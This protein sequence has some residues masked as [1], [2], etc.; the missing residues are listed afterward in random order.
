MSTLLSTAFMG[1]VMLYAGA[2]MPPG[3]LPCDGRLLPLSD[4]TYLGL[5]SLFGTSFGG[6]GLS[7]FALPDLRGR[8]PLGTSPY[9]GINPYYK[10]GQYGGSASVELH[11]R[12]LPAHTHAQQQGAAPATA[13]SPAD[14]VPAPPVL[15]GAPLAAYG[16][17]TE[18]QSAASAALGSAGAGQEVPTLPPYLALSYIICYS[19]VYPTGIPYYS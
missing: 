13:S 11:A 17:A 3:W 6:D 16:P 15:A 5:F 8:L 10:L 18:L 14:N 12:Q 2:A 9:D 1:T 4:N 7:T 19:G